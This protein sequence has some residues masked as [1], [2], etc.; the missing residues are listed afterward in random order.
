V[1]NSSPTASDADDLALPLSSTTLA[2]ILVHIG[3]D[4][5]VQKASFTVISGYCT[6]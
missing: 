1:L 6:R 5:D 4:W 2:Y 3:L